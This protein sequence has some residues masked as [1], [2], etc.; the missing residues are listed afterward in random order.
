MTASV[1]DIGGGALMNCREFSSVTLLAAPGAP[2]ALQK[3]LGETAAE[4]KVA[5][6][7]LKEAI[8]L[9]EDSDDDA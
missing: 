5:V 9:D 7:D 2:T 3:L 1:T 6:H 4:T 8:M